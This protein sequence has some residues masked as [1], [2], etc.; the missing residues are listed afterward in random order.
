MHCF[1]PDEGLVQNIPQL[2]IWMIRLMKTPWARRKCL[3]WD[4][5]LPASSTSS[6]LLVCLR[7][8]CFLHFLTFRFVGVLPV[9]ISPWCYL[10]FHGEQVTRGIF[11]TG[12]KIRGLGKPPSFSLNST[13]VGEYF[14]I[15][16][17]NLKVLLTLKEKSH[18]LSNLYKNTSL[19]FPRDVKLWVCKLLWET[20]NMNG[21]LGPDGSAP[22][23][24]TGSLASG[25]TLGAWQVNS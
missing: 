19:I 5:C 20:A 3:I 13:R 6:V 1:T 2:R 15:P 4:K 12:I 8:Q 14:Q 23:A 25:V 7:H 24:F 22:E 18:E 9:S 16:G 10:L 21:A 11:L 17:L